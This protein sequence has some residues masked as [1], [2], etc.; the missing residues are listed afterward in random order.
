MNRDWIFLE[1]GI[2][3]LIW[4]SNPSMY[5]FDLCLPNSPSKNESVFFPVENQGRQ[6]SADQSV[7]SSRGSREVD[8]R[9][10]ARRPEWSGGNARQVDQGDAPSA[11][12]HLERKSDQE[13]EGH[14]DQDVRVGVVHQGVG[15]KS[16]NLEMIKRENPLWE[17]NAIIWKWFKWFN[18]CLLESFPNIIV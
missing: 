11:L 1:I 5:S 4:K 13:L 9:F 17:L 15:E 8:R 6:V 16:P 14:V 18:V 10:E 3:N 12:R 2:A 7:D